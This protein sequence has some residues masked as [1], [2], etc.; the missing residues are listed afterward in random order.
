VY[1]VKNNDNLDLNMHTDN[2]LLRDAGHL[3]RKLPVAPNP[4]ATQWI[5]KS[6]TIGKHG[7]VVEKPLYKS[8][9][10]AY[11]RMVLRDPGPKFTKPGESV[12]IGQTPNAAKFR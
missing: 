6:Q 10:D 2:S 3:F 1:H 9:S 7:E 11:R 5:D 12:S 8:I 4:R